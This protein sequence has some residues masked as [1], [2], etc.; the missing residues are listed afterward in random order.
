MEVYYLLY[1]KFKLNFPLVGSIIEFNLEV[2]K[3]LNLIYK[4]KWVYCIIRRGRLL[5][6]FMTIKHCSKCIRTDKIYI[7]CKLIKK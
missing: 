5:T 7:T 6:Q 3:F 4:D 1:K 2:N